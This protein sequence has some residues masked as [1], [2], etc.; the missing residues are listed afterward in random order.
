M[1]LSRPQS[2]LRTKLDRIATRTKTAA[3]DALEVTR[4][5]LRNLAAGVLPSALHRRHPL[6][7]LSTA[8]HMLVM[9]DL[10]LVA[11]VAGAGSFPD[12]FAAE[13][14]YVRHDRVLRASHEAAADAS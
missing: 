14:L 1:R 6:R 12:D 7:G 5:R 10:Y 13:D 3:P 11:F 4:H 2:H 8:P 9:L